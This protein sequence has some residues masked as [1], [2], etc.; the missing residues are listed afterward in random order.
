MP[1]LNPKKVRK[2]LKTKRAEIYCYEP[3]TIRL[4][5]ETTTFVQ[6]VEFKMDT[7]YQ[8]IGISITSNKH[9]YVSEERRLLKDETER[10]NDRRKHRRTRRNRKRYRKPRFNNRTKS[11]QKGWLAP[12][13]R[14]KKEQH[15]LVFE[16]YNQIC[17]ITDVIVEIAQ[18][19]THML[20][21]MEEGKPAPVGIEYQFGPLYQHDTLRE[22]VFARDDYTCTCCKKHAIRDNLVLC[23]HH[24][25]YWKGDRS[26]RMNN[27]ATVCTKCHTPKN[28]QPDGRLYGLGPVTKT[29]RGAAFMN[30]VRYQI[31]EA[32]KSI[33]DNVVITY[34]SVTKRKRLNHNLTKT[35]AN[36][37]YCM[38]TFQPKHR[39]QTSIYQKRRR[40]NRIL[41]KFYD[42]KYIDTRDGV[43]RT[44]K[45]LG[46]QRTNRR[47]PRN[48]DKNLRIYHGEKISKGRRVI[49]RRRYSLQPHSNQFINKCLHSQCRGISQQV[50]YVFF[51]ISNIAL[52]G[53]IDYLFVHLIAIPETVADQS[54]L[55]INTNLMTIN[56]GDGQ[57]QLMHMRFIVIWL[58]KGI[59][60]LEAGAV[61]ILVDCQMPFTRSAVA[62]TIV[63]QRSVHA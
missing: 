12:S 9:E 47:A 29:F 21:A 17:P 60:D 3:F 6:P 58:Y 52:N 53:F 61:G 5:Y 27:L 10:H 45:E 32:F 15:I 51:C 30:A 18:F 14:N 2:L 46:C 63:P 16:R 48:T 31:Y 54:I 56:L 38:G 7:G 28:H 39:C 1:C 13:L 26:N 49:R 23:M 19:D 34:G 22:A 35:H 36:D 8:N 57:S 11:K 33:H 44:G 25:G 50:W 41:E 20:Q 42:A 4:L 37:A 59:I 24:R 43:K 40:N 62:I 55:I